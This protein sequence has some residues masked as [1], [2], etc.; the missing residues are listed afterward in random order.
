M[1]AGRRLCSRF[2]APQRSHARSH[3]GHAI[4]ADKT[5]LDWD[6]VVSYFRLLDKSSDRIRVAELGKT[7]EGRP[8]IAAT[9]AAPETLRHLDRYIDIQHRL[10]DPR[11]TT[12]AEAEKLIARG[13]DV[14]LI[15]CSIHATEIA[16]TPHGGRVR[17]PAAHR[18]QAALPARFSRTRS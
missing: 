11:M 9:I 1:A 14:V 10:A 4:G 13:Q 5:V 3:F 15:T 12:P 8:F 2:S 17:L 18:R 16:S 6:K 7:T